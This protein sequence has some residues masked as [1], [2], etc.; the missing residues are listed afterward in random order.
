MLLLVVNTD[1]MSE[2]VF[3]ALTRL[4]Y[5]N[6]DNNTLTEL[7]QYKST[8]RLYIIQF[9]LQLI[10]DELYQHTVHEQYN[11]VFNPI[12]QSWHNIQYLLIDLNI[13]NINQLQLLYGNCTVDEDNYVVINSLIELLE[14]TKRENKESLDAQSDRLHIDTAIKLIQHVAAHRHQLLHTNVKLFPDYILISKYN[15]NKHVDMNSAELKLTE[16]QNNI[17]Q[18]SINPVPDITDQSIQ[19]TLTA[20][21]NELINLHCTVNQFNEIYTNK[22]HTSVQQHINQPPPTA[23]ELHIDTLVPNC[24]D[25]RNNIIQ[26][27]D[28]VNNIKQS[29]NN[30]NNQPF[31]SQLHELHNTIQ[32]SDTMKQYNQQYNILYNSLQRQLNNNKLYQY[33]HTPPQ[34]NGVDQPVEH[35]RI[36]SR[37]FKYVDNNTNM[38]HTDI[39]PV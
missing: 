25:G 10:D 31:L 20:L 3:N 7:K 4:H 15:K 36:P 12:D 22:L 37:R 32:H 29:I 1:A 33:T 14:P 28:N 26:L 13:I 9:L 19:N 39:Q 5:P 24:I 38:P 17:H 21:N 30:I 16:L 27:I 35:R 11:I 2:Q 6:L 8:V 18:L 23:T 34:H